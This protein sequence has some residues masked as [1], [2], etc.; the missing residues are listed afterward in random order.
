MYTLA[1]EQDL[2]NHK[3]TVVA[4]VLVLFLFLSLLPSSIPFRNQQETPQRP[5]LLKVLWAKLNNR[6]HLNLIK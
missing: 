3:P 2:Y 5:V 4:F 1:T 6:V